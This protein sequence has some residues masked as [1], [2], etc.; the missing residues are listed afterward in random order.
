[1]LKSRQMAGI[2]YNIAMI[3]FLRLFLILLC[4]CIFA[5]ASY[6]KECK[7]LVL[8]DNIQFDSTNYYIYPASATIFASD[9]INEFK[10]D[11]R[12]QI[13]K[14]ADVR[15]ALRMNVKLNILT[16]KALK[17]FKYNYNIPFVDLKLIAQHFST[18]KILIITSQTDVQN[19]AMRRTFWDIINLPGE[20]IINPSY[21]LS[22]YAALIDVENEQV[23]W[24]KTYYKVI[25]SFEG[26][27]IAQNF[28]PATEQ[29]EKIKSYSL[30]YLSPNISLTV[31]NIL[32]PPVIPSKNEPIVNV[33]NSGAN[34]IETEM[35]PLED[36][37]LKQKK[38]AQP[39]IIINGY[40]EPV[41]DL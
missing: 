27:I 28:S 1:M 13:V 34:D 3:R 16:K 32:I 33:S 30:S 22:T 37:Q 14:M 41:N 19:Y 40:G 26:R 38:L 10:K 36:L 6:A 5:H 31:Q 7:I 24:Q 18:N 9:V 35:P 39:K 8:P 2:I 21:K 12:I 4:V 20:A 15:E 11:G 29:L 25:N 23:L 17:E